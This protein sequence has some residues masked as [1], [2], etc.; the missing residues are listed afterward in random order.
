MFCVGG[1]CEVK[2]DNG[3]ETEYIL[4]DSPAK[5]I[6]VKPGVWREMR[7]FEPNATLVVLASEIYDETDYIRDYSEFQ[8]YLK[9]M[10]E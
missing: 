3:T 4:L 2:F 10:K 8:R 5:C 9:G 6:Y 7:K 1:S